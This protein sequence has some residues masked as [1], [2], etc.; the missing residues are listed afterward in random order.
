MSARNFGRFHGSSRGSSR[1]YRRDHSGEGRR[2]ERDDEP[3]RRGGRGGRNIPPGLRG[4]EIGLYFARQNRKKNDAVKTYV[5]VD[6][7]K[8]ERISRLLGSFDEREAAGSS[9]KSE[10]KDEEEEEDINEPPD[11]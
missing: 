3:G 5:N 8:Q 2:G 4:K 1:G 6:Q 11:N 7:K 10:M 9:E